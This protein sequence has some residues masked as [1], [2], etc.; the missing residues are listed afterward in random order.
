M[1]AVGLIFIAAAR[2]ASAQTPGRG[3][4]GVESISTRPAGFALD[5]GRATSLMG[6]RVGLPASAFRQLTFSDAAAKVDAAGLGFIE[7]SSDQKVG[8][9]IAKNLDYN[10]STDEIAAVRRRLAELR[11]RMAAY[12]TALP[13]DAAGRRKLFEF[14][15]ALGVETIVAAPD[16]AALPEIDKLA[17]EF[18]V[19]VAVDNPKGIEQPQQAHRLCA[20]H[21]ASRSSSMKDRLLVVHVKERDPQRLS[22]F[23]SASPSSIRRPCPRGR[24][25]APTAALRPFRRNPSYSRST[26]SPS[27]FL[28]KPCSPPW[29]IAWTR[30]RVRRRSPRPTA[31]RPTS[32]RRSRRACR[33]KRSSS[34]RRRASCW[35]CD[36]CPN[37]GYY[38]ATIAH[39]NLALQLMAKTG[40]YEPTFSNDLDNL[41]YPKIKQYDAVF[42]NS[43]VGE[44]FND[45]EVLGGLTRFV[46]EGGGLAGIHG[47]TYASMDLRNTA[48]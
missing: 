12:D 10:L 11:L 42:L 3:R 28:P 17:N 15:K 31:Y 24:P 8:A 37:G 45:P 2:I 4:G 20:P 38:H 6:W 22:A 32:D 18:G 40:A 13:S 47:S 7:G 21:R 43:V 16:A 44:L 19:N 23:F 1:R 14:A 41:K 25:S 9:G 34:R 36:L 29:V 27:P 5:P 35:S 39:A 48:I 46:R 33:R 26:M 30:S